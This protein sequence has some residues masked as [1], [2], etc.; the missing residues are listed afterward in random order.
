MAQCSCGD[1]EDHCGSPPK[2]Y[3]CSGAKQ[4]FPV[5]KLKCLLCGLHAS[6]LVLLEARI[7]GNEYE[8]VREEILSGRSCTQGASIVVQAPVLTE[9]SPNST[10]VILR[11]QAAYWLQSRERWFRDP[12]NVILSMYLF[13]VLNVE[14]KIR[15]Q[16]DATEHKLYV[17]GR[18]TSWSSAVLSCASNTN[19]FSTKQPR[20]P[21]KK[22]TYASCLANQYCFRPSAR[23]HLGMKTSEL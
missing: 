3:N 18:G 15:M 22:G 7:D 1:V 6:C 10:P 21:W 19:H 11:L 12:H 14:L 5:A 17:I 13:L 9:V 16:Q 20:G 8:N 23:L 2:I 4:L